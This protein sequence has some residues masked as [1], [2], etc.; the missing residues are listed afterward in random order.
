VV[1]FYAAIRVVA[2]WSGTEPDARAIYW[3]EHAGFTW[4]LMTALLLGALVT[5]TLTQ[6]A[7][8]RTE[9]W[10]LPAIVTAA[11]AIALQAALLP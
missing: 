3:T 2:S 5:L 8:E 11:L 7:P 6:L 1:V 4:R 10:L 9:R